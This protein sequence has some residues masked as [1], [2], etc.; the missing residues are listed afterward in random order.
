MDITALPALNAVLNSITIVFLTLGFR[1]IKRGNEDTHK[2]FMLAALITSAL[3]LTS[4]VIY[5]YLVGSVPYPKEDWT[6][7]I[8]FAFLIPHVILA[9]L[10][11]PF[12]ITMVIHA[13]RG[14]FMK[15]KRIARFIWPVWM[16]VSISG[17]I[18]YLM[19][20]QL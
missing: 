9:A 4:Y 3:F 19:L 2:K 11:T 20:Y 16:F 15:H 14:N 7:P 6:R 5:H 13:W 17:V 8:Y 18:V 12:I 10:M 1:H